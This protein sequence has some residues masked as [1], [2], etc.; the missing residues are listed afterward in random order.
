VNL[1]SFQGMPRAIYDAQVA[2]NLLSGLGESAAVSLSAA[3]ARIRRHYEALS[4]GAGL[5]WLLQVIHAPV[6]HGH[7]FSI[8][9][10]LER[11][12]EIRRSKR[13]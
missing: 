5:S 12:A 6:F 10:E 2:Y 4:A 1:L 11:P 8:A 3:E 9:V 7:T 13:H